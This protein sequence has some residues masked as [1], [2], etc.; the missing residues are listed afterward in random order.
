MKMNV[1]VAA[2]TPNWEDIFGQ[3]TA[4][5]DERAVHLPVD[6]MER[7]AYFRR[8]DAQRHAE[9]GIDNYVDTADIYSE[10]YS[11]IQGHV[12][13]EPSTVLFPA[14]YKLARDIREYYEVKYF[15]K[16]M[17]GHELTEFQRSIVALLKNRREIKKRVLGAAIRLFDFYE[18]DVYTDAVVAEYDSLPDPRRG[19]TPVEEITV[20]LHGILNVK[21]KRSHYHQ[22]ITQTADGKIMIINK[23]AAGGVEDNGLEFLL[24]NFRTVTLRGKFTV[25]RF[26]DHDFYYHSLIKPHVVGVA[27]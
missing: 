16:K 7:I 9:M 22:L 15:N 12:E 24:E 25:N 13:W 27:Q 26:K 21:R 4:Q 19:Y 11:R 23:Q 17:L 10:L 2:V 3:T 8:L 14:D 18:E 6:I 20:S 5:L 1:N